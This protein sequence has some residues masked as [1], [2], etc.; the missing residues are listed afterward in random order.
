MN[1]RKLIY[2]LAVIMLSYDVL[3]TMIKRDSSEF[4]DVFYPRNIIGI[5]RRGY[6]GYS[7]LEKIAGE[8]EKLKTFLF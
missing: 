6:S 3:S 2:T 4:R 7:G 5:N 1:I 8:S